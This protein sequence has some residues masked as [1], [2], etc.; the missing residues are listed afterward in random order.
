[1]ANTF[2]ALAI[3]SI[4][5]SLFQHVTNIR[6][7]EKKGLL[8]KMKKGT[9]YIG[10]FNYC[11]LVIYA[12]L[13]IAKTSVMIVTGKLSLFER[14][15][16]FKSHETTQP[17]MISFFFF[18]LFQKKTVCH[19]YNS[20]ECNFFFKEFWKFLIYETYT[21]ITTNKVTLGGEKVMLLEPSIQKMQIQQW[22]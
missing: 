3:Q 6:K 4:N 15:Q 19:N 21:W 10:L 18:A 20:I 2:S 1:M 8:T 5:Q 7:P 11:H 12:L 13:I 9:F 14:T 17:I 16:L 22:P